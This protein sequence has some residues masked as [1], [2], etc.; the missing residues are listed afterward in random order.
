MRYWIDGYNLLFRITKSYQGVKQEERKI[1]RL[2]NQWVTEAHHNA[3]IVFDGRQKNMPEAT[4]SN[5]Q[6]L[7]VIYTAEGEKADAYILDEVIH[8]NDPS[9]EIVI[10]SDREL[11][12]KARQ[13]G[14]RIKSVEEFFSSL[15]KK[16]NKKKRAPEKDFKESDRE[17]QRLLKI[18]EKDL[19][20]A[21]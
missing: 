19:P 18:F 20:P 3:T 15:L 6:N 21:P 1:L 8:S 5:F 4:R 13:N 17:I 14:A 11:T 10:S 2:I 9:K 16:R 7:A 12:G